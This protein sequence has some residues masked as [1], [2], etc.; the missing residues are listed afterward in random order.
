MALLWYTG[1]RVLL[2]ATMTKLLDLLELYLAWRRVPDG[3]GG[4][5]PLGHLRID[6]STA[7]EARSALQPPASCPCHP[8]R[9]AA[10][11][12]ACQDAMLWI[13]RDCLWIS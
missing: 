6:G 10:M 13:C 5:M 3:K 11:S 1:H 8:G 7:L 4:T 12:C 2:F 9:H